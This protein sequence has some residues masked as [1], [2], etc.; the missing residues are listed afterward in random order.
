MAFENA[1][2]LYRALNS[3]KF[4]CKAN[5]VYKRNYSFTMNVMEEIF[6]TREYRLYRKFGER[7]QKST[8]L[9][10]ICSTVNKG[11]QYI[12]GDLHLRV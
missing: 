1:R 8:Q 5:D 6:E 2:Q 4:I 7:Y 9:I 10:S 3:L 12:L 11:T